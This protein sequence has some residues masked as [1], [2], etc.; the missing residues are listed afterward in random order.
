M[1]NIHYEDLDGSGDYSQGDNVD[2]VTSSG[3]ATFALVEEPAL[4]LIAPAQTEVSHYCDSQ[5]ITEVIKIYGWGFG[6][7]QSGSK[8][9]LG[10]GGM[11]TNDTGYELKRTIWS[12]ILI[13]AAV[14]VPVPAGDPIL[15]KEYYI[16]LDKE[17]GTSYPD[18][19]DKTDASYGWPGLYLL[20]THTCP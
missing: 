14:D 13:K 12:D 9:Y 7:T 10:T 1:K 3:P 5:L 16:W 11:W 19:H 6:D 4:Y 15:D 8:V 20:P 17:P 2:M 18:N